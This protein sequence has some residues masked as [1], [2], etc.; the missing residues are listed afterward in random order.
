MNYHAL[1]RRELQALC[2]QHKIPANKTNVFMADSLTAL[3]SVAEKGKA[4]EVNAPTK[5]AST[6]IIE[7]SMEVV[8]DT[9]DSEDV[10]IKSPDANNRKNQVDSGIEDMCSAVKPRMKRVSARVMVVPLSSLTAAENIPTIKS[11]AVEKARLT[12]R[13][14]RKPALK[15]KNARALVKAAVAPDSPGSDY[16]ASSITQE[17]EP[18]VLAEVDFAIRRDRSQ[19]LFDSVEFEDRNEG[20]ACLADAKVL[21]VESRVGGNKIDMQGTYQP[22]EAE[23]VILAEVVDAVQPEGTLS[24]LAPSLTPS[25]EITGKK[26]SQKVSSRRV[27]AKRTVTGKKAAVNVLPVTSMNI[28]AAPEAVSIIQSGANQGKLQGGGRV[29]KGALVAPSPVEMKTFHAAP[30]NVRLNGPLQSQEMLTES[31]AHEVEKSKPANKGDR[32]AR[33]VAPAALPSEQAPAIDN[34]RRLNDVG[35]FHFDLGQ[36]VIYALQEEKAAEPNLT[37]KKGMKAENGSCVALPSNEVETSPAAFDKEELCDDIQII[38]SSVKEPKPATRKGKKSKKGA[39]ST[40]PPVEI[41]AAPATVSE[42]DPH[43]GKTIGLADQGHSA[44][45][46]KE[47]ECVEPKA[48]TEKALT[49]KRKA[50][51]KRT[52][53]KARS[54]VLEV[55][56]D[57][58]LAKKGVSDAVEPESLKR[59]ANYSDD[60][61]SPVKSPSLAD[62]KDSSPMK[63][64]LVSHMGEDSISPVKSP[65]LAHLVDNSPLRCPSLLYMEN[66]LDCGS[67]NNELNEGANQVALRLSSVGTNTYCAGEADKENSGRKVGTEVPKSL[68]KLRKQ[69]KEAIIKKNITPVSSPLKDISL[70]LQSPQPLLSTSFSFHY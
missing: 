22:T 29:R 66:G 47:P 11:S 7:E 49:A 70:N 9:G 48:V 53:A 45:L 28:P 25:E 59:L 17:D 54:P 16:A 23:N 18:E 33:K 19:R 1:S 43:D 52:K 30:E 61:S 34:D 44:N 50:K 31:Q 4:T 41:E 36:A 13:A 65:S 10:F 60:P 55:Y 8:V 37:S 46:D 40:N 62:M 27:T 14:A 5:D 21:K 68:R 64:P 12:V 15:S 57:T 39:R 69:V 24:I 56:V 32:K 26:T 51:T 2:K 58:D 6:E 42:V 20:S 35:D 3:L 67:S 63:S 38:K